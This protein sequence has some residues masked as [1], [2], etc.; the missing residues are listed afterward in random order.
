[1]FQTIDIKPSFYIFESEN[2]LLSVI[3]E[4]VLLKYYNLS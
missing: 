2:F 3:S 1:M 4:R